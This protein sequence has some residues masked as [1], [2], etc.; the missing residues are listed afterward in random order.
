MADIIEVRSQPKDT[1]NLG[2]TSCVTVISMHQLQSESLPQPVSS[3]PSRKAVGVWCHS[4]G[5]RRQVTVQQPPPKR[6]NTANKKPKDK[7]AQAKSYLQSKGRK[8]QASRKCWF[9]QEDTHRYAVFLDKVS[10][11]APQGP[12]SLLGAGKSDNCHLILLTRFIPRVGCFRVGSPT[13]ALR[14]NT[15]LSFRHKTS[16]GPLACPS[17]K[18]STYK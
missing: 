15:S 12:V 10:V 2:R 6:R 5:S 4:K 1:T 16:R 13:C 11:E 14:A 17:E 7:R 3:Y 9:S 8:Q 18:D